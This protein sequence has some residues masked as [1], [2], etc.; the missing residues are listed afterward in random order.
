M[1]L[2]ADSLSIGRG[3]VTNHVF[4]WGMIMKKYVRF[5]KTNFDDG[6]KV[7][8]SSSSA[9]IPIRIDLVVPPT[10]MLIMGRVTGR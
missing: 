2:P 9:K 8:K 7:E 6:D 4:S 3:S 1:E 5:L 10:C